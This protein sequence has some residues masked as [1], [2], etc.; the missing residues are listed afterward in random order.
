MT[1]EEILEET[2][3]VLDDVEGLLLIY[4]YQIQLLRLRDDI[5]A[6]IDEIGMSEVNRV[7][8]I[9]LSAWEEKLNAIK[10]KVNEWQQKMGTA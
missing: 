7:A 9:P 6:L 2:I 8:E 10:E 1:K 5:F 3:K 4:P